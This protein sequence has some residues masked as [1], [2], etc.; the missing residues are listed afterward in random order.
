MSMTQMAKRYLL[1]RRNALDRREHVHFLHI[2]K[3]AGV[4]INFI[5]ENANKT[6]TKFCFIKHDHGFSL[7]D[8]PEGA[9]YFFSIRD[10]IS[11]FKSAF[12]SRK[13]KGQPLFYNEWSEAEA[14]AFRDFEHANDLAG[15]LFEDSSRGF[16]AYCAMRSISHVAMY[17]FSWFGQN[18]QFLKLRPPLDIVR[19][20]NF[21]SDMR[22]LMNKIGL[23]AEIV[24]TMDRV[25]SHKNDYTDTPELSAKAIRNLRMWYAADIEFYKACEL[26]IK[27]PT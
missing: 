6:S 20:E 1:R 4:Q 26:W 9:K 7:A 13:R 25:K 21:D 2:G 12:Y 22:R 16:K 19:Q 11:R 10:P 17:Q 8:I 27:K 14:I 5:M 24:T 15:A 3:N 23:Y 18:G